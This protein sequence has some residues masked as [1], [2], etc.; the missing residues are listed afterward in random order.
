MDTRPPG[1]MVYFNDRPLFDELTDQ[2]YRAMMEAYLDYRQYQKEPQFTD[3]SLRFM[4]NGLK[5]HADYDGK[6]Y[7]D[8]CIKNAYNR[9]CGICKGKGN[10]PLDRDI[11]Y[12]QIYIPS[13]QKVDDRQESSTIVDDRQRLRPNTDI[14]EKTNSD[15]ERNTDSDKKTTATETSVFNSFFNNDKQ[16]ETAEA[17]R[18]EWL[19]AK[20]AGQEDRMFQVRSNLQKFCNITIDP[21]GNFIPL[22]G[23]P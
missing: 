2:E 23:K 7:D 8:M 20:Q 6:K 19:T 5:A 10:S 3:R 16:R 4:W 22:P 9:Y 18:D 15:S 13:K 12:E 14:N 21:N 17:F 11:W 1:A